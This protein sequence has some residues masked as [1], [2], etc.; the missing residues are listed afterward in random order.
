MHAPES[1]APRSGASELPFRFEAGGFLMVLSGP[2]GAGKGTLVEKL[3]AARP[4]CTFAT[5]STRWRRRI[6]A[7]SSGSEVT[8]WQ[9][10]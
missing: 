7:C 4:V 8:Q 3:L 10:G 5:F 2:S 9:R 1:A 6:R